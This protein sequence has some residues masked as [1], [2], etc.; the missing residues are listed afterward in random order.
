[1]TEERSVNELILDALIIRQ[2]HLLRFSGYL[3][4]RLV[5]IINSSEEEVGRLIRDVL[6]DMPEGY[7]TAR[8]WETVTALADRITT[9]RRSV[10]SAARDDTLSQ[11]DGLAESQAQFL[12]SAYSD[13]LPVQYAFAIPLA[14]LLKSQVRQRP[15][16]GLT[17]G[18]WFEN[19]ARNDER[20]IRAAL[21]G[22]AA[23]GD[24]PTMLA[25]RV[26]GSAV[27]GGSDGITHIARR[28][29]STIAR[30]SVQHAAAI[31]MEAFT[32]ANAEVLMAQEQFSA[33]LDGHTT[34]LCRSLNGKRYAPG[35]GPHPPL[36]MNCRSIRF[37][38]IDG[39][40]ISGRPIRGAINGQW[41]K[42][43]GREMGRSDITSEATLPQ[44]LR[45]GYDKWARKRAEAMIG[46]YPEVEVYHSW[47]KKQPAKVQD[48]V[49]GKTKGRLFR[50]GD[51]EL[52]KFI[53][54]NGREYNLAELAKRAPD[55]F[56]RAGLNP[57]D[58]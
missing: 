46:G 13:P 58:F 11:V 24:S 32:G 5:N 4:V 56:R 3:T 47:L 45:D 49:L 19:L 25:R 37:S 55:A 41:I 35:T 27:T 12:Q 51:L 22:G 9:L 21:Y 7:Q 17:I 57:N 43:F 8:G 20:R 54:L 50:K 33:V 30:T 36:H 14:F 2:I 6:R 23:A 44:S 53:D 1:M 18:L 38:V 39:R 26:L 28:E 10:W 48:D 40:K 29:L 42:L 52:G 34:R 31:V 15:M 16:E